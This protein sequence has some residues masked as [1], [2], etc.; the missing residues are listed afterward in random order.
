MVRR[1]L[2]T[3][4]QVFDDLEKLRQLIKD[5][6]KSYKVH[7]SGFIFPGDKKRN[8]SYNTFSL[9]LKAYFYI[10]SYIKRN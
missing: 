4:L 2:A 7:E 5:H 8:T 1:G 3:I 10:Q 6:P 9:Y